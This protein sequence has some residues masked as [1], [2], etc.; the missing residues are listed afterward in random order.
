M[1]ETIMLPQGQN[2]LV[3]TDNNH[4]HSKDFWLLQSIKDAHIATE[5]ANLDV[6]NH[7][8]VENAAT[9]Q[10]LVEH[11]HRTLESIRAMEMAG[12]RT[13]LSDAKNE[14]TTLKITAKAVPAI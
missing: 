1:S 2:G 13:Q 9:R 7:V 3:Q 8:S 14:V 5:R 10:L 4:N 11:A 6:K 12:L